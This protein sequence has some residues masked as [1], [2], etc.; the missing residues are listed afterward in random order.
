MVAKKKALSLD[1]IKNREHLVHSQFHAANRLN[2]HVCLLT[3][4]ATESDLSEGLLQDCE[5]AITAELDSEV[6][7]D[8]SDS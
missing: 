8:A 5:D 7:C 6:E 3:R 4:D 2:Y 1:G